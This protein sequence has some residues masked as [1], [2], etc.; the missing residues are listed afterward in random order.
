MKQATE[1][2]SVS[3][4][5]PWPSFIQDRLTLWDKLVAERNEEISKKPKNSIKVTLPDGKVV[6]AVAWGSTAY[7]VAKQIRCVSL[8]QEI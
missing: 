4:L 7:D 8:H 2:S 5:K 3:E 1:K 6:E